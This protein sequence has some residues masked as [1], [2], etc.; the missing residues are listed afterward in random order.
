MVT[1]PMSFRNSSKNFLDKSFCRYHD[2]RHEE[3]RRDRRPG[4]RR[5]QLG[6]HPHPAAGRADRTS[7]GHHARRRHRAAPPAGQLPPQDARATW[8]GRARRG[9]TQGQ[10]E[11]EA[12]PDN[13]LRL[14]DLTAG[15]RR[16]RPGPRPGHRRMVGPLAARSGRPVGSRGGPVD[17]QRDQGEA[18]A[19]HVRRGHRSNLRHRRRP[20]RVRRRADRDHRPAHR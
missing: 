8:T 17:H 13:G 6:P 14:R 7:V 9:A 16:D 15:P 4:R 10:C 20:G 2:G 18:E 3:C 19:G 5:G 1:L 12:V 11:R